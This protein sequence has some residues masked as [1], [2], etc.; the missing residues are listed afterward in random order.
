MFVI[1]RYSCGMCFEQYTDRKSAYECCL[2]DKQEHKRQ[3]PFVVSFFA[4]GN[5][6]V[7]V[8]DYDAALICCSGYELIGVHLT[9]IPVTTSQT[10]IA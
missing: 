2:L 4:C 7:G 3:R 6:R 8:A 9:K 10:D 1:E 5:C